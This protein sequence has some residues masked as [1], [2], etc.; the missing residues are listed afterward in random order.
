MQH[1]SWHLCELRSYFCKAHLSDAQRCITRW[2]H[3]VSEP[4][5]SLR[6]SSLATSSTE[7]AAGPSEWASQQATPISCS[8]KLGSNGSHVRERQTSWAVASKV[9]LAQKYVPSYTKISTSMTTGL[10]REPYTKECSLYT[11]TTLHKYT[12]GCVHALLD[13]HIW[14]L[15]EINHNCRNQE[16]AL[17]FYMHQKEASFI[18]LWFI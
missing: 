6:G 7:M 8:L 13:S 15:G 3:G 1:R 4:S 14:L 9:I 5:A 2:S 18:F 17:H 12:W 16:Y 11:S 10:A